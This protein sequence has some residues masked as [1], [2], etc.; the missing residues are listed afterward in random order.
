MKTRT[1]QRLEA[2]L[3]SLRTDTDWGV[4]SEYILECSHWKIEAANWCSSVAIDPNRWIGI[5]FVFSGPQDGAT[6]NYCIDTDLYDLSHAANRQFAA[7]VED[8]ILE[9][10]AALR[11]SRVLH[12]YRNGRYTIAIP[13]SDSITIIARNAF[14][15][16]TSSQ[17]H[18]IEDFD[19]FVSL[20]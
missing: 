6:I 20:G 10:I 4:A 2:L 18:R 11:D 13:R 3:D 17:T 16:C 7:D 5:E 1:G 19:S 8:E 14:G 15:I 12:G 9:L